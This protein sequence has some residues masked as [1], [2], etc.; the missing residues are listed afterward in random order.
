LTAAAA[1]LCALAIPAI[2]SAGQSFTFLQPGFTQAIYGV[3]PS[4]MGGVAFAPDADPWVD[5]CS[6]DGSPLTRFDGS[7]TY[8]VNGTTLHPGT[9]FSSSAGCGLANGINGNVYTNT[10][11]GVRELDP[12]TGAP[13]GG[14]FGP[15]GNALGIALDPQTGDFVYVGSDGTLY[16]VNESLTV[17]STFSTVTTGNFVDGVAWS[18]DGNFVFLSN[19]LPSTRLT[20]LDR[21][22]NLVQ[23]VPMTSEPDGIAF[24]AS[25]PRF[26]VTNNTNGTMTRFDFPGDDYTQVPVQSVFASGGFRGDLSQVGADSCLYLTQAGTR[27]DNGTVTTENSLVQICGGLAPPSITRAGAVTAAHRPAGSGFPPTVPSISAAS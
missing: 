1:V 27:Y 4:F 17:A 14:P 20:I 12:D 2:A 24:H 8:V 23:H 5:Q 3:S 16:R 9:V 15:T 19:R 22:G 25:T 10:F 11:A 21:N 18:P 6:V 7:S 13:I 26:V